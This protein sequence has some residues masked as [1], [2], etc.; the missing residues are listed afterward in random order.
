MESYVATHLLT[1]S[2]RFHTEAFSSVPVALL[3]LK[4]Q[5]DE[6]Q[7]EIKD[8]VQRVLA[9]QHFILGA[10]V[11]AFEAEFAQYVGARFA[12][13]CG[14][15]S[16]ALLLALMALGIGPDDEVITTPFTFGATAGSIARLR[17][18][19]V[20]VDIHSHT[21]N[22]DEG[23]IE[24][25]ISERTCAIMPV[26]LFG[27]PSNM[28]VILE[29]ARLH[30]L[31]VI[32]DAAQ[33]VGARWHVQPVGTLGSFGCF[34]FFPSKNLG[35]AG[36]G[37]M[38]TTN[39]AQSAQTVRRLRAHGTQRKYH[40]EVIGI[41]SRL[42]ALQAAIL[43]V[44]LRH[45]NKW[46]VARMRNAKRYREL[47]AE[48]GLL[49]QI[50]LPG[51]GSDCFHVYNQYTI[52]APRRDELLDYLRQS[53]ISTEIYYP[54][55]LHLE[56]AFAYLGY[57]IGAFPQAEAA[58]HEVLSLPIY[59]ELTADKQRAVVAAIARFYMSRRNASGNSPIEDGYAS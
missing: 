45:L 43:R 39:D 16:D 37:G 10:E 51:Q 59:P 17:A 6:I 49:R 50:S 32:E 31:P 3:D 42:D 1:P 19:P 2:E 57:R 55:P 11:E 54:S 33:A 24:E 46:T 35:G 47:F 8:A 25:A 53:T 20:F 29:I 30:S 44:K 23:R 34:S 9:S 40:Y 27:L 41:N 28:G 13:G 56:P 18:R 38:I 4:A 52:R 14:S 7:G 36:D 22:L 5:Y 15:G 26:H 21:F 58:C 48:Y 12:I